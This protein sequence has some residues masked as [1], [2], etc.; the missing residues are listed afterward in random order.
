MKN[1]KKQKK[2]AFRELKNPPAT[3]RGLSLQIAVGIAIIIPFF[4]TTSIFRFVALAGFLIAV[5]GI[6]QLVRNSE[7]F[8]FYYFPTQ[9]KRKS[10]PE[11]ADKIIENIG[12]GLFGLGLFLLL[13]RIIPIDN[14]IGGLEL[15]FV[16][17][18]C[19]FL[20]GIVVVIFIRVLRPSIFTVSRQRLGV[21]LIYTLGFALLFVVL[22]SFINEKLASDTLSEKEVEIVTKS[23][24]T[25]KKDAYYIFIGIDGGEERIELQKKAWDALKEGDMITLE[26]KNGYF[27]YPFISNLK[28]IKSGQW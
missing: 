8:L 22:A 26:L 20:F 6:I 11:A 9:Y 23:S 21:I 28:K 24:N 17:A 3:L 19:G 5:H 25:R 14:T 16:S 10:K 7:A 13:F 1:K 4:S 18:G 2:N 12:S 27:N 15:F